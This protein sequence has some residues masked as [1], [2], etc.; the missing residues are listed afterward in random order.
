MGDNLKVFH[1]HALGPAQSP[2]PTRPIA[3]PHQIP[4]TTMTTVWKMDHH[5]TREFVDSDVFLNRISRSR[6]YCCSLDMSFILS[7]SLRI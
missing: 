5:W 4:D 1:S 3:S 7:L 6:W 2:T